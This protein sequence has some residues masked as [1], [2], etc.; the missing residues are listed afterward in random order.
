MYYKKTISGKAHWELPSEGF[1]RIILLWENFK[2]LPGIFWDRREKRT[3]GKG[4]REKTG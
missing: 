2:N 4:F 3:A 1:A